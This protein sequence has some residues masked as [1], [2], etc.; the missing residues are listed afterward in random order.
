[1]TVDD[2]LRWQLRRGDSTRTF[3]ISRAPD[4][5]WELAELIDTRTVRRVRVSDWH[6]VERVRRTF[7]NAMLVLRQSGWT[8]I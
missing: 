2:T 4:Y 3:S 7:E 5:G 1:M 6:R 8:E